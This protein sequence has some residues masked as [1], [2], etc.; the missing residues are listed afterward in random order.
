[1]FQKCLLNSSNLNSDI[2]HPALPF[3]NSGACI[4][5]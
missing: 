4:F 3:M 1:M 5:L 2:L